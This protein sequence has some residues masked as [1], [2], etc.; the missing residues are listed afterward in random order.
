VLTEG[1]P[2]RHSPAL[3]EEHG[4][5]AG[6]S[7]ETYF[8]T[9][10]WRDLGEI[11]LGEDTF[12]IAEH[13][14]GGLNAFSTAT[15]GVNQAYAFAAPTARYGSIYACGESW[16]TDSLADWVPGRYTVFDTNEGAKLGNSIG[17]LREREYDD[18]PEPSQ[19]VIDQTSIL[20]READSLMRGTMPEG[21]VSTFY[22]EV[23]VTW[24]RDNDIV[25]LACFPNRPSIL[26]FG[27]LSQPLDPYQSIQNPTGQDVATHLN[28]LIDQAR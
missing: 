10:K 27:N 23:N 4:V 25:R 14:A 24:R 6:G 20:V 22:G 3:L 15:A 26:Q 19:A 8:P 9:R 13:L 28:A 21:A 2:Q 5:L 18:E 16:L 1:K 12:V 17:Q 11:A 7:L